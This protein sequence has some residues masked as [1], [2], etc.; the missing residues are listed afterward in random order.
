[1][2]NDPAVLRKAIEEMLDALE[3]ERV[4]GTAYYAR[5][6]LK[7]LVGRETDHERY[8]HLQDERAKRAESYP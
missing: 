8:D 4:L 2:E 1:M 6:N 5:E 7:K 3:G